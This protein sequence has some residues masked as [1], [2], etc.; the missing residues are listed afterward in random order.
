MFLLTASAIPTFEEYKVSS[1][2]G[3]KETQNR[4]L[5]IIIIHLEEKK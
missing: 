5:I 2:S 3:P 1:K 4:L